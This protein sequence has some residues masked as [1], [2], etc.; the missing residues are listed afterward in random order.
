MV[1]IVGLDHLQLAMPPGQEAEARR[2]LDDAFA[3]AGV[4]GEDAPVGLEHR[5]QRQRQRLG[6]M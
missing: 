1:K 5:R 4:M 2:A 3:A 6:A